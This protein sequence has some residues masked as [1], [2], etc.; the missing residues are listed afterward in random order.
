MP[1]AHL[2]TAAEASF[3]IPE[4]LRDAV[5]QPLSPSFFHDTRAGRSTDFM[6][7]AEVASQAKNAV[8]HAHCKGKI[9]T[10]YIKNNTKP[11]FKKYQQLNC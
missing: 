2:H 10:K 1:Q 7:N 11:H 5:L 3:G 8:K 4:A 6:G 9:K